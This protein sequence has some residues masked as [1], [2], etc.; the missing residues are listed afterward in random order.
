M[1][2]QPFLFAVTDV[3]V[4]VPEGKIT[5]YIVKISSFD[6]VYYNS[7]WMDD[8]ALP[9]GRVLIPDVDITKETYRFESEKEALNFIQT[10]W[11][12]Q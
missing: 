3:D 1:Q 5:H 6:M 2:L 7:R 8:E 10:W 11:S 9:H 4:D 12:K